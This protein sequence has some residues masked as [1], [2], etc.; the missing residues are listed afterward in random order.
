MY[1]EVKISKIGNS[2]GIILPR[3]ALNAMHLKEN[4]TL[5]LIQN[6]EGFL[7]QIKCAKDIMDKN[8]DVLRALAQ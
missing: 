6:D 1:K 7:E 4:D 5:Y 3:E 2:S 8:R